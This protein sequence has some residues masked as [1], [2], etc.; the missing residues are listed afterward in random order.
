MRKTWNKLLCSQYGGFLTAAVMMFMTATTVSAQNSVDP[1]TTN[2]VL[3]SS[4]DIDITLTE[5]DGTFSSLTSDGS[6]SN[7]V[8]D[9]HY[10]V[11]G[12]TYSILADYLN[13]Q[14]GGTDVAFT[15]V[16]TNGVNPTTTVS[17]VAGNATVDT[18]TAS[19][20]LGGNSNLVVSVTPN[21][22]SVT[23]LHDGASSL[24]EDTD[25]T[26]SGNTYT[27]LPAY[28]NSLA[29]GGDT[30]ITFDMDGGTDPQ[31]VVSVSAGDATVTPSS[32][33]FTLGT[34]NTIDF[35]IT[36][37][38]R[39]VT[40][41]HD[42]T[43][44]LVE[45][46]D[47]EVAGTTY[48][49]LDTY[50]D[51]QAT[52]PLSLAF[53]MDGG[54]NPTSVVTV[55]AGNAT[56][57]AD[58]SEHPFG[59]LDDVVVITV[60]PNG[61]SLSAIKNGVATLTPVTDYTDHGDDT[62]TIKA[63]YLND[64]GLGDL[65]LTLDMDGGTDPQVTVTVID[66][67]AVVDPAASS[68]TLGTLVNVPI[69]LS[70]NGRT[71]T[72]ITGRTGADLRTPQDYTIDGNEYTIRTSYL[73][74]Q[75]VGDFPIIFVMS[76]GISPT[77]TMTIEA[78]TPVVSP[79]EQDH[80]LGASGDLDL[81]LNL[82]GQTLADPAV[83]SSGTAITT[84]DYTVAG[85]VYTIHSVYLDKQTN[86]TITLTFDIADGG[87]TD[88]DVTVDLL[89]GDA[90]VS[91][92]PDPA[93][94]ARSSGDDLVVTLA[95]NGHSL[96]AIKNGATPLTVAT[97][98][99]VDVT[100]P[101]NPEYTI[102]ASY[103]QAQGG[104]SFTL[105]FEMDG[106]TNPV[107]DVTVT[108]N[109]DASLTSVHGQSDSNPAGGDGSSIA[110]AFV[111]DVEL[112]NDKDVLA[113]SN[114]VA[115][116]YADVN[117]YENADFSSSELTGTN[118]LA[119]S[120]GENN[121][122]IKVT[123]EDAATVQYYAVTL[124]RLGSQD[125]K[126]LSVLGSNTTA[127]AGGTFAAPAAVAVDV[128]YTITNLPLNQIVVSADATK[129]VYS[130]AAYSDLEELSTTQSLAV[131]G[132]TVYVKVTAQDDAYVKYYNATITRDAGSNTATLTNVL[133]QA[134]GAPDAGDGSSGSPYTK[135]ITV[136]YT[137]TTLKTSDILFSDD[138]ATM[139]LYSD[140]GFSAN[141]D[142][143]LA[144]TQGGSVNA[145][146]QIISQNGS[147]TNHYDITISSTADTDAGL[148]TVLGEDVSGAAGGPPLTASISVS[149]A[150]DT[151]HNTN[152]VTSSSRATAV[153]YTDN[154]YGTPTASI[155]LSE[156][157]NNAYIEVTAEDSSTVRY[158]I[159]ITRGAP[160][161]NSGTLTS[162]LGLLEAAAVTN[163]LNDADG[164][165][166]TNRITWTFDGSDIP[167]STSVVTRADVVVNALADSFTAYTNADY[168]VANVLDVGEELALDPGGTNSLYLAVV[169][170]GGSATNYYE[171]IMSRSIGSTATEIT[172]ILGV[173]ATGGQYPGSNAGEPR[174]WDT[175]EV[176]YEVTDVGT[177]N[178][179]VSAGATF[180][181][182]SDADFTA[183]VTTTPIELD[184]GVASNIFIKVFAEDIN[185]AAVYHRAAI[186]RSAG[187]TNA[188]LTNMLEQ[189]VTYTNA[190]PAPDGSTGTG[191]FG[192]PYVFSITVSNEVD[193]IGLADLGV[194][195]LASA[196]NLYSDVFLEGSV[197]TGT[198]TIALE[199]TPATVVYI[200]ITAQDPAV[201][202]FYAVTVNRE[203]S[204]DAGLY[205]V[206][207][208][209]EA[210]AAV[211][212]QAGTNELTAITWA[213][214]V[215][216]T[217][218][219]VG[220]NDV[221]GAPASTVD[222][223]TD[224]AFT[225]A[226]GT[227]SVDLG[228]TATP[229]YIK[230]TS[231]GGGTILYYAVSISRDG[232]LE[233]TPATVTFNAMTNY[234]PMAQEI[235]VENSSTN[236]I[237]VAY[238][239]T[240]STNSASNAWLTIDAPTN[241]TMAASS[242]TNLSASVTV[243]NLANGTYTATNVFTDATAIPWEVVVTLTVSNTLEDVITIGNLSQTYTGEGLS[244]DVSSLSGNTNIVVTYDGGASL[245]INAG[246]YAVTATVAAVDNWLA[247]TNTAE[248]VI[249]QATETL[250]FASTNV[251][252]NGQAKS[253]TTITASGS[254]QVL[255]TYNGGQ[256]L[257]IEVGT[258]DVVASILESANWLGANAS[259]TL[260]ISKGAKG[261]VN[262]SLPS[263][264]QMGE[265]VELSADLSPAGLATGTVTFAVVSGPGSINESNTLSFTGGGTVV[266]GANSAGEDNF[267]AA[268]QAQASVEVIDFAQ[269]E[270]SGDFLTTHTGVHTLKFNADGDLYLF[271]SSAAGGMNYAV[272][273]AGTNAFGT[274]Q[275]IGA[276]SGTN[277]LRSPVDVMFG[278]TTNIVG[279]SGTLALLA[280]MT[281]GTVASF[282]NSAAVGLRNS[283]FVA[284]TAPTN[285]LFVNS[286]AS[287][288][289][290][291]TTTNDWAAYT[292]KDIG[293]G[294][295]SGAYATG[296][297][298]AVF[299]ASGILI[300]TDAGATYSTV[301]TLASS[302]ARGGARAWYVANLKTVNET[303]G[304]EFSVN[305]DAL[306]EVAW[307]TGWSLVET[308]E[309]G[310]DVVSHIRLAAYEN[311]VI[312]SWQQGSDNR[313]MYAVTQDHGAT[314]TDPVELISAPTYVRASA[315]EAGYDIA[316]SEKDEQVRFMLAAGLDFD[317]IDLSELTLRATALQTNV[318]L[319]W[320]APTSLGAPSDDVMIRVQSGTN[321]YPTLSSGASIYTGSEQLYVHDSVV[322]DTTYMYGLWVKNGGGYID[323][324]SFSGTK[325]IGMY[326]WLYTA[327]S[328]EVSPA[329][330]N[331]DMA[332]SGDLSL[333]FTA[334][335]RSVTN[336]ASDGTGSPL[337]LD[338][339]YSISGGT[340][341]VLE[342]YLANQTAGAT[343]T[344]TF[345]MDGG[346][347]PEV[348][349][350][351]LD[352]AAVNPITD[353]FG[354]TG[355]LVFTLTPNGR[356]LT[357]I[358]H[359]GTPLAPTNDYTVSVNDY[360]V[361]ESYLSTLDL[362]ENTLTF[363]MDGGN[364]PTSVVT[365][366]GDA[367]ISPTT[368]RHT[369]GEDVDL[370]VTLT[371][372]GR[373]LT[374]ITGLT[375]TN[376]YTVA[377]DVY[378]ILASYM[379]ALSL[380]DNTLTFDM[381]AGADPTAT[382]KVSVG[383]ALAELNTTTYTLGTSLTRTI[384]ITENERAFNSIHDGNKVLDD[385]GVDYTLAGNVIT[386]TST[387]LESLEP[388]TV[389]LT[390]NMNAGVDPTVDLF[391]QPGNAEV[392]VP[393]ATHTIDTDTTL[394][395]ELT[396][397]G[398]SLIK[399][400][401]T[402]DAADLV[403]TTDYTI[404]NADPQKPV[405]TILEAYLDG[406]T[407]GGSTSVPKTLTFDM[408]G[409]TD[410][411]TVVT[412]VTP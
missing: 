132:N 334:N 46:T 312:L 119:L 272:Q 239:T 252:Y 47:Y 178:I 176:G 400:R 248:L 242:T 26:V 289:M 389:T 227:N 224:D 107:V 220:T 212:D 295:L 337:V 186:L 365:V 241:F 378:S 343:V 256:D 301:S 282:A 92:L 115:A 399:I 254:D 397:N 160:D 287:R 238:V 11:T 384:T 8:E 290:A 279:Q 89:D 319:R 188:K 313:L 184:A 266:V 311:I 59:G 192:N 208:K 251:V 181:L 16:M 201:E 257:P 380:G 325:D 255:V 235:V 44:S 106:G 144:L 363:V 317:G 288:V 96:N 198:N 292:S 203:P 80:T 285:H 200:K 353:T 69:T 357:A 103:I 154:G 145:Y 39:S 269:A 267:N 338:T 356:T 21:G 130:T 24:V 394:V 126:I 166:I 411:D 189:V 244:V 123:S 105:T 265:T 31:T 70:P 187:D 390:L 22:R 13:V 335:G 90:S 174:L 114:V 409:G 94:F 221:I 51:Q 5:D 49:I 352:D 141:E 19:Y 156:G 97:N 407:G 55:A 77:N 177:N 396:R 305:T 395:I 376:D 250:S 158:D 249:G 91:I 299:T 137:N 370:D 42:G 108:A 366:A 386:L 72:K 215:P 118:T 194:S 151:L 173:A 204:I 214:T 286:G 300:S 342:N 358:E 206:L 361:L 273:A 149:Y 209:T 281:N 121:I 64:Q 30:T 98:Y 148:D 74:N 377:G 207:D 368:Y 99:T 48:T 35:V 323:P 331:Y 32:A 381:A 128:D 219:T 402:T 388:G 150:A 236:E 68:H 142:A 27:I 197:V 28:L 2:H 291:Y 120:V 175:F 165:A 345:E 406:L 367:S 393:T 354:G 328:A 95:L 327:P 191:T 373:E 303:Y 161:S 243:S 143:D 326:E 101:L 293:A 104:G 280:D 246:T 318:Y 316:V 259:T 116:A 264:V 100:D 164:S 210:D 140:S 309:M 78:G 111:W 347:N 152:I 179:G 112:A 355:N 33:G 217:T 240:Y 314:W 29:A 213:I 1:A 339:D 93:E 15:F 10:S 408:S 182:Y 38:G 228:M 401:N 315:A 124:Y 348:A 36:L 344:L 268:P 274:N 341:T 202:K 374:A 162:V 346:T 136:D 110:E 125:A 75:P 332:V 18:E 410:P 271:Y 310:A 199:V 25:Y 109:D 61:R 364:N 4:A 385:S 159:T 196:T 7:L 383:N 183:Q 113:L 65:T 52:G 58:P 283:H 131:G 222:V 86:D 168:Q 40:N 83:I 307:Q 403:P 153:L 247:S 193:E 53:Q 277:L 41:L 391:V 226:L 261:V 230:V 23:N 304:I 275:L 234:L 133:G 147:V 387:Y 270:A 56:A 329:T 43:S 322:A 60:V 260:T 404:N 146:I 333:S 263:S 85:N 296:D 362:G 276:N 3:G 163:G 17:I 253:V 117:V 71:L 34:T 169:A 73:N 62:Y 340:I 375:E 171:V 81:I 20:R 129:R 223:Y 50:L 66:G 211:G 102:L 225:A 231:Q 232:G 371:A 379:D 12:S 37:N 195:E 350:A 14:A 87:V 321:A 216:Y 122:Y 382:I 294:I 57:T 369:L 398:R 298:I 336:V 351:I 180:E 167:F 306:G 6:V 237:D 170:E 258:Y 372:R 157:A 84:N 45:N 190:P 185:T 79:T 134:I 127:V 67:D 218:L 392:D 139:H 349:I 324:A 359:N 320:D 302:M 330:T 284:G 412:I 63:S 138:V 205:S 245:P 135:S 88:L 262:F 76:G 54:V 308:F 405:I 155:S 82:N 360:T 9:T 229:L 233:V 172:N 297:T 278:D